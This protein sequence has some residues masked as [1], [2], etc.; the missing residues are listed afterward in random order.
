MTKHRRIYD[1]PP[2]PLRLS[3]IAPHKGD[4]TNKHVAYYF[5]Y[6]RDKSLT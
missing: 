5:E 1:H 3:R 2:Y 4:Y 6:Q